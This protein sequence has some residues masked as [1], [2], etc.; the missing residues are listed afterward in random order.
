MRFWLVFFVVSGWVFTL[1]A[2]NTNN[3]FELS[4]R[5]AP[6]A[7]IEEPVEEST[8][9]ETNPF[10]L[11]RAGRPTASP[12]ESSAVDTSANPFDLVVPTAPVDGN[13][14]ASGS[15]EESSDVSV[16]TTEGTT[17]DGS[18][19]LITLLLLGAATLSIIFFRGMYIKAYRALFNDNL[20]SQ[21]YREREAGALGVFL[22]TYAVFFLAA[23]FFTVLALR[24]WGYLGKQGLWSQFMYITAGIAGL[25]VFK[26]LLLAIIGYVFPVQKETSRYSFTIMIFAIVLGLFLTV[27]TVILAYTPVEYQTPVIYICLGTMLA[28]YLLRSFRG[29]FIANRFIFNYQFHFLSYICAVEIGPALCLFKYLTDF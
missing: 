8:A 17:T 15:E 22:I 29:L 26:H 18:L 10:D 5:L 19:L 28:V 7:Q 24:H 20:L 16:T 11:D 9:S 23:G 6:A 12:S 13:E 14:A 27:G 25:M 4:P 1:S 3:P 2:Q 21:L